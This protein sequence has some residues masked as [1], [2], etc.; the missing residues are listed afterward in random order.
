MK[1]KKFVNIIKNGFLVLP[2]LVLKV[3]CFKTKKWFD[4]KYFVH[5]KTFQRVHNEIKKNS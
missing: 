3:K 2:R 5:L 1:A 4:E